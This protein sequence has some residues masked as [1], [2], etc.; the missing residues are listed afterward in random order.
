MVRRSKKV[1]AKEPTSADASATIDADEVIEKNNKTGEEQS[2]RTFVPLNRKICWR[3]RA[4]PRAA[5]NKKTPDIPVINHVP[6]PA[7]V[8]SQAK[9]IFDLLVAK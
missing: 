1:K 6:S 2:I 8:L 7:P 5:D 3:Q 9:L 4:D